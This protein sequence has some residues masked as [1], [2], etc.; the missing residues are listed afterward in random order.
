MATDHEHPHL[1]SIACQSLPCLVFS[2]FQVG[3][4]HWLPSLDMLGETPSKIALNLLAV[5]P[6]ITMCFVCHYNVHPIVS[7]P[8]WVVAVAVTT[9]L[10]FDKPRC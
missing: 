8:L 3:D 7:P 6:V 1:L 9:L 5:L 10:Q 2:A 4:F